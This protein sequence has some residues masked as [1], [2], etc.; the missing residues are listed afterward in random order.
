VKGQSWLSWTDLI[1][2]PN[3]QPCE[4]V[5]SNHP[6]YISA[7]SG[8]TGKRKYIQFTTVGP[9][10]H[11]Q[12]CRLNRGVEPHEVHMAGGS[13]GFPTSYQ[14]TIFGN[15]QLGSTAIVFD[16]TPLHPDPG[17][18]WKMLAENRVVYLFTPVFALKALM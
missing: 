4:Y 2:H 6:L 9:L 1:D 13:I 18:Y 10:F 16:G 5:P 17:F 14:I 8:T 12:S 3:F 15:F 11:G 7:T